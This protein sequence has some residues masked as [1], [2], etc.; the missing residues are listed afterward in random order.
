MYLNYNTFQIH[1]LFNEP[2]KTKITCKCDERVYVKYKFHHQI[3]RKNVN[4]MN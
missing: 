3:L 4:T 1:Q 2:K